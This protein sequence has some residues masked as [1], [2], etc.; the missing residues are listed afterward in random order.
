MNWKSFFE[1]RTTPEP[2]DMVRIVKMMEFDDGY[3]VGSE[4]ELGEIDANAG[5]S[6]RILW[7]TLEGPLIL[8][9]EFVIIQ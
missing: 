2:G 3:D 6:D 7:S 4:F 9:G 8:Q 5:S 1:K